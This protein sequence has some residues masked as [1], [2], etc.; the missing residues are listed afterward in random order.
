MQIAV[1]LHSGTQD[2]SESHV[3]AVGL[4][5]IMPTVMQAENVM[6][7]WEVLASEE[8]GLSGNAVQSLP[9]QNASRS[10]VH[11]RLIKL[12]YLTWPQIPVKTS[13]LLAHKYPKVAVNPK[14]GLC[15]EKADPAIAIDEPLIQSVAPFW[16]QEE[17]LVC[18]FEEF[19]YIAGICLTMF[20]Y[21]SHVKRTVT[22][23]LR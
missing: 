3:W 8:Q 12:Q 23:V 17:L 4:K 5:H 21:Q 22:S 2:A 20:T 14:S 1:L 7:S 15:P 18:L 19:T 13:Q 16:E 11:S 10:F 9:E 6:D